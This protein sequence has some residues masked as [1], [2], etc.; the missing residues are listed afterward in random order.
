MPSCLISRRRQ[1]VTQ[2]L[3]LPFR[4]HYSPNQQCHSTEK[5]CALKLCAIFPSGDFEVFREI[6]E[7][8][9]KVYTDTRGSK[10]IRVFE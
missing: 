8:V 6:L 2:H 1:T 7:N 10:D 3:D 4:L 5:L 9:H